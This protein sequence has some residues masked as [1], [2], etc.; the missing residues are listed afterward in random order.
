M[1]M[2]IAVNMN[3]N[4][5]AERTK[6]KCN[7]LKIYNYRVEEE[8]VKVIRRGSQRHRKQYKIIESHKLKEEVP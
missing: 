2:W 7:H 3:I 5:L 8:S 6:A 4:E 1:C